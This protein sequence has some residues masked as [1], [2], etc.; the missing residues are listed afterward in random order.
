MMRYKFFRGVK[1]VKTLVNSL[2]ILFTKYQ[3]CRKMLNSSIL[4]FWFYHGIHL[5]SLYILWATCSHPY[6][7]FFYSWKKKNKGWINL[8]FILGR[9]RKKCYCKKIVSCILK[10]PHR[11][12]LFKSLNIFR[13]RRKVNFWEKF[14]FLIFF[15]Y[16]L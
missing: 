11:W 15:N 3:A 6:N 2:T 12:K 5:S 13:N 16:N 7:P 8:F 10:Y 9:N 1:N 14:L 4:A